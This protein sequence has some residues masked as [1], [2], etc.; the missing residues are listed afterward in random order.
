V[1]AAQSKMAVGWLL[2]DAPNA[3]I[4]QRRA[5]EDFPLG[6]AHASEAGY[7]TAQSRYLGTEATGG[8]QGNHLADCLLT[9]DQDLYG[10]ARPAQLWRSRLWRAE[11]WETK[12]CPQFEEPPPL[13]PLTVD[14]VAAWL[15]GSPARA[16]VLARLLSVLEDP[17]GRRV[18][19][20]AAGPDE[21]LTWIAAAT[22]LLPVRAA[23]ELS[24]KVFCANPLRPSHR[25]VAVPKELQTQVTAGRAGSAF[26][27][28]AEEASSNEAEVSDRAKFW[29]E[30]LASAEDPYDVVDAVE[31]AGSLDTG[32]GRH[33]ADAMRTAW[34]V[35]VPDS[36]L[37]DPQVL[38]RWLS[39]ADS[40]LQQEHG[41]SV[42]RRI[43]AADPP[44]ATLQWIDMKAALGHIDID[45]LA[46]RTL[47]LTAEIAEVQA[48]GTPPGD[49]LADVR[50]DASAVRD[51]DSELSSA[52]VLGSDR[53]VDLLLRLSRRHRIEP[54]LPPLQER[55][56]AFVLHWIDHPALGYSPDG[57]ALREQILD[58]A[59]GELQARLTMLGLPA[60]M[61]TIERLWPY[62]TDR[63]GDPA[64][65]L[66]CHLQIAAIRTLRAERGLS[67]L[68]VL[69]EQASRSPRAAD[70]MAGIQRALI[71][72]RAL[73]PAEAL[74][75]LLALPPTVRVAPEVIDLTVDEIQRRADRPTARIL[76]ALG[77]LSRRGLAPPAQPFTDLL[78][79]D[80]AVLDFVD[81]S[82][83]A[84]SRQ[85][86]PFVLAWVAHLGR[87]DPAVVH[88]RLGLLLAACLE[89]P[90]PGLGT[91]VLGVLPA[92]LPRQLISLW[93]R[94][95]RGRGAVRAA[96]WGVYWTADPMLEKL[97]PDIE[98]AFR[99]FG[100]ALSPADEDRWFLAVQQ[101]LDQELA[102]TWSR[103]TGH[104]TAKPRRGLRGRARD[105]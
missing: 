75:V 39:S 73:G 18:V 37:A 43:L 64:D 60:V 98:A 31:L 23:L 9:R 103:I 8:R 74:L 68:S 51:A 10:P 57:W 71:E 28:D 84:R 90:D 85:D 22:L 70:A 94:E 91:G 48:G 87:T 52:I 12:D 25:I 54:Q 76:D 20:A 92:P 104:E 4:M 30:L 49:V 69:V 59:H 46:A 15:Q 44:A 80:R 100:S 7:G 29:V 82:R 13:G 105:A 35:T 19:I 33:G 14:A 40:K 27:L 11:A 53:Q 65:P 77:V 93:A 24:F 79:A 5:V 21:A 16:P 34:A 88:C 58:L 78:A 3:W 36:V 56:H 63:Q 101:E 17:A 42:I 83:S 1:D 95:L 61:G 89:F 6:F 102:R 81:A 47:L 26:V 72:W 32:A 66:N 55:L 67:R 41:P 62:F 38:F 96:V 86:R 45:R 50:P 99:D 2:Y 97:S